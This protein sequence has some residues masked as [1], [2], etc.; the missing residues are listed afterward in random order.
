[1]RKPPI[2]VRE[3][4]GIIDDAFGGR[5]EVT[6]LPLRQIALRNPSNGKEVV[7]GRFDGMPLCIQSV[8]PRAT[9]CPSEGEPPVLEW[10]GVLSA[11]SDPGILVPALA[12]SVQG[13]ATELRYGDSCHLVRLS[14]DEQAEVAEAWGQELSAEQRFLLLGG[15][16][17]SLMVVPVARG[18]LAATMSFAISHPRPSETQPSYP[19]LPSRYDHFVRK[20]GQLGIPAEAIASKA[21]RDFLVGDALGV[22]VSRAAI[23]G[24][25][26]LP[27]D[28][29][30]HDLDLPGMTCH[31]V[32]REDVY[33]VTVIDTQHVRVSI[34]LYARMREDVMCA[35]IQSGKPLG[36]TKGARMLAETLG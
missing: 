34:A 15:S 1:M 6:P 16:P 29:K 12:R 20:M 33:E 10:S 14:D 4:V 23:E 30:S 18:W 21:E 7:M 2:W 13:H 26:I 31:L 32:P 28:G 5:Y 19:M 36:E 27:S 25:G 3:M 24:T 9:E 8:M 35:R 17:S 11:A 22:T